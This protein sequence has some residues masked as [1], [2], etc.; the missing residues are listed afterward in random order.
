MSTQVASARSI[1]LAAVE[2]VPPGDRAGYVDA[3]CS[4]DVA[5]REEVHRLLD[6][7]RDLDSFMERPAADPAP[8]VDLAPGERVGEMIGRYRLLEVIGEGGMGV[9]YVAEQTEPVRRRVA[10]KIIKPGMDTRQVVARFEAERQA[11]ALMDHPNIAK[12]LDAG[13]VGQAFQPANPPDPPSPDL[14]I[15]NPN[16]QF[17]NSAGRPY[18]VMEL[19]RG[20][21][22]TDYCDEAQLD[23]RGRLALFTTACHAVQHAH[24]K[25]VIHRDIKPS[26]VLVTLHDGRPVVK[27]IDFGIAKAVGQH[28]TERTIY[29]AFTELIGTPL[30]MSPEQAELSGLDVDTRS[31]VYSLGVLLYELLTGQTPFD[32]ES[33]ASRGLDEVRRMIREDEPPR[34]SLRI[35]TLKADTG[36]TVSQKRGIDHRQLTRTLKGEL[37]WIVMKA[38]EKDRNR[39]YESASAFAADVERYLN[40]EPVAAGPPSTVYRFRKFARRRRGVLVATSF[41]GASLVAGTAVSLWQAAEANTARNSAVARLN[42][43]D[44]ILYLIREQVTADLEKIPRASRLQ[45]TIL[46]ESLKFYDQLLESDPHN[47]EMQFSRSVTARF[48]SKAYLSTTDESLHAKARDLLKQAMLQQERLCQDDPGNNQKLR[49]LGISYRDYAIHGEQSGSSASQ[50]D[51]FRKY[52]DAIRRVATSEPENEEFQ[53]EYS[54]ALANLAVNR[55]GADPAKAVSLSKEALQLLEGLTG[56]DDPNKDR[57]HHFAEC[58]RILGNSLEAN[59]KLADAELA[60]RKWLDVCEQML[61]DEPTDP[62]LRTS[63][64]DACDTIARFLRKQGRLDEEEPFFRRAVELADAHMEKFPDDPYRLRLITIYLD[65][66]EF[67]EQKSRWREASAMYPDLLKHQRL[68]W[69]TQPQYSTGKDYRNAS[70]AYAN[71]FYELG[72]TGAAREAYRESLRVARELQ[73]PIRGEI[74][75]LASHIP[76]MNPSLV[77]SKF[78]PEQQRRDASIWLAIIESTC[79]FSELRSSDLSESIVPDPARSEELRPREPRDLTPWIQ[80]AEFCLKTGDPRG[81]LADFELVTTTLAKIDPA[82]A[83]LSY[84]L[85]RQA[86]CHDL[87]AEFHKGTKAYE[88]AVAVDPSNYWTKEIASRQL[89]WLA[90][91]LWELGRQDEARRCWAAA[92]ERTRISFPSVPSELVRFNLGLAHYRL[93]Q[94]EESLRILQETI[95]YLGR[96]TPDD[97]FQPDQNY[98]HYYFLAMSYASLRQ[99]EEAKKWFERGLE[100]DQEQPA[101]LVPKDKQSM[102]AI[103]QEAADLLG[104]SDEP[105]GAESPATPAVS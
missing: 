51:L 66:V 81:A 98:G 53:L 24:Q 39:R 82:N 89:F 11:L 52:V 18:F 30:Y 25:G 20:L 97:D 22:I 47:A 76:L 60:Y 83:N 75:D 3:A 94:F 13:T 65:R 62:L 21:P 61:S 5:L 33:L 19:V 88:Q 37:D 93:G 100:W 16:S 23:V 35:S 8:T 28:L 56:N 41:I 54:E 77:R 74:D 59:D 67:F 34:P 99:N 36:S 32:R 2:E 1:F 68:L 103:R 71:I 29:T 91:Q 73:L 55:M 4:G 12:I 49:Q 63:V 102:R 80:R 57:Q 96:V 48:L 15:P 95:D 87:L 105:D 6:V 40:N 70:F 44:G 58:Y 78:T 84:L 38:L 72:E 104:I 46:E 17:P 27:V 85:V 42:V 69:E 7:Y 43:A 64:Q 101:F 45:R 9:V 10:L 26:N 90:T 14:P 31:D 92:I 86:I 50:A 79:P